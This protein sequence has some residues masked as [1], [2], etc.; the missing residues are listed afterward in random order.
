MATPKK[1]MK[2]RTLYGGPATA[3]FRPT[4]KAPVRFQ[5]R[6]KVTLKATATRRVNRAG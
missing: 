3:P 6:K 4:V 1:P 5:A 2:K